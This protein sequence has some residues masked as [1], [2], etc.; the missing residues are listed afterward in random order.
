MVKHFIAQIISTKNKIRSLK[1]FLHFSLIR[2]VSI[3][4]SICTSRKKLAII[5]VVLLK[6]LPAS[7]CR[8]VACVLLDQ[9]GQVIA[10]TTR[11]QKWTW[12]TFSSPNPSHQHMDGGPTQPTYS[13]SKQI[14]L[15]V[16]NS[17]VAHNGD[18]LFLVIS[19]LKLSLLQTFNG[20]FGILF[21][22]KP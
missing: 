19:I 11:Y 9:I 2:T 12:V 13:A 14:N 22:D 8:V 21:Y 18:I 5:H 1:R 3:P 10:S 4:Y 20:F 17:G 6:N 16:F 7:V 15:S